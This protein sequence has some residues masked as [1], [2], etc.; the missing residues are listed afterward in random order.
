[1]WY[2]VAFSCYVSSLGRQRA[3]QAGPEE[4][5]GKNQLPSFAV[6][7]MTAAATVSPFTNFYGV[8]FFVVCFFLWNLGRPLE[9]WVFVFIDAIGPVFAIPL[10]VACIGGC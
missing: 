2:W 8:A 9:G 4:V 1:M 3:L 10:M 7:G 6:D 5:L